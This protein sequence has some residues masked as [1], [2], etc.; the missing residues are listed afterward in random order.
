VGA[1][2]CLGLNVENKAAIVSAG[3]ISRLVA[4]VSSPAAGVQEAAARAL[5]VLRAVDSAVSN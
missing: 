5:R 4:L 3:A 1:L 2:G